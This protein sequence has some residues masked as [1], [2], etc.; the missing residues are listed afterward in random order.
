MSLVSRRWFLVEGLV[1]N[2]GRGVQPVSKLMIGWGSVLILVVTLPRVQCGAN[3]ES[4]SHLL[5]IAMW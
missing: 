3:K 1:S 4:K 5:K 2:M